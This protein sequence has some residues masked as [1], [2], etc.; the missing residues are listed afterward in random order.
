MQDGELVDLL[1]FNNLHDGQWQLPRVRLTAH[2]LHDRGR[3]K[4]LV[5]ALI[6]S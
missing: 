5:P 4:Q 3:C 6:E 1:M 2:R